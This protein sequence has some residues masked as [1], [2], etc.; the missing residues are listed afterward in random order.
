M[1]EMGDKVP[2]RTAKSSRASKE[3][4]E[5]GSNKKAF[6]IIIKQVEQMLD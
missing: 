6:L 2:C 5:P 1:M 3:V 4:E